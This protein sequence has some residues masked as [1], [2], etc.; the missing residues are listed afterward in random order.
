MSNLANAVCKFFA[1]GKGMVVFPTSTDTTPLT[2]R[3]HH[4]PTGTPA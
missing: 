3:N 1:A 2:R 4:A